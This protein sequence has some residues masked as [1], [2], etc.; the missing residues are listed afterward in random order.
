MQCVHWSYAT[1]VT[2]SVKT[3]FQTVKPFRTDESRPEVLKSCRIWAAL[4]SAVG[5]T[6]LR[7]AAIVVVV[8][9]GGSGRARQGRTR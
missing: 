8:R 6:K 4:A 5:E 3:S 1:A 9:G 2:I 7:L